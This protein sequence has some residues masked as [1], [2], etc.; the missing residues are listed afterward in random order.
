MELRGDE[1]SLLNPRSTPFEY[2][3]Q[4]TE[5]GNRVHLSE[6]IPHNLKPEEE[7]EFIIGILKRLSRKYDIIIS[8]PEPRKI[9]EEY[10]DDFFC[11]KITSKN[12]IER[13]R[14]EKIID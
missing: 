11:R 10:D 4:I 7:L 1:K 3:L 2:A 9:L 8:E 12:L 14:A 13:L 5:D 6:H